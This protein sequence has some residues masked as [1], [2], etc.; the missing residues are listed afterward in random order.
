MSGTPE[1]SCHTKHDLY[2]LQGRYICI[3]W[4]HKAPETNLP[5]QVCLNCLSKVRKHCQLLLI[6]RK[7]MHYLNIHHVHQERRYAILCQRSAS[8]CEE[9]NPR[10]DSSP[11]V[12]CQARVPLRRCSLT[13]RGCLLWSLQ[14][15]VDMTHSNCVLKCTFTHKDYNILDITG[16][17]QYKHI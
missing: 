4:S 1:A 11:A 16:K 6:L 3:I 5:C 13:F 12:I 17:T 15:S 9:A 14:S 10:W 7:S 2:D 8:E